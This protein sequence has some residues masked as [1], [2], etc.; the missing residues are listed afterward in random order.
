V[1]SKLQIILLSILLGGVILSYAVFGQ[2]GLLHITD[3]EK[4]IAAIEAESQ[5]LSKENE[6]LRA[7]IKQLKNSDRKY[8]EKIAR[9]ELGMV[10]SDEVI[11]QFEKK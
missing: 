3:M 2:N 5:K 8:I 1:T 10:R 9:E 7:E 11:F 6:R 4:E